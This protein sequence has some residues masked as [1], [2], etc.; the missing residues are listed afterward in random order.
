MTE[1]T[2]GIVLR[3][4]KYGEGDSIVNVLTRSEGCRA[5]FLKQQSRRA[6]QKR[7]VLQPL[8]RVEMEWEQRDRRA[9]QRPRSLVAV[10][11]ESLPYEPAKATLAIFLSEFLFHAVKGEPADEQLFDYVWQSLEWLDTSREGFSN[12][13]L[14]FLM[15]LSYFLGFSPNADDYR[16]GAYFDM[17]RCEFP[18]VQPV[19]AHYLPPEE[20]A[21]LP[22]ILRMQ[23][24]TMRLFRFNGRQRSRLL[25][26]IEEYY[27][28]HVADFP[29][30]KSLE[31]LRS[32]FSPESEGDAEP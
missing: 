20:A 8:A 12:F 27:R 6:R 3:I 32:V 21:L 11:Y 14:V 23:Y 2:R 15:K 10:P 19:H 26:R 29:A 9:L 18:L 1:K 13:H 4:V 24:G 5:F 30:L 28:L 17:E 16:E 25:E 7:S 22:K 31:V